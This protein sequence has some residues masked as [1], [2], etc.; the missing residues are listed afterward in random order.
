MTLFQIF[1]LFHNK[2][3][4]LCHR[5]FICTTE[6]FPG[7]INKNNIS[8]D[9]ATLDLISTKGNWITDQKHVPE[10]FFQSQQ[11]SPMVS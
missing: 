1:L 6:L 2:I 9:E 5:V 7:I 11:L 10:E 3:K 8:R 4:S